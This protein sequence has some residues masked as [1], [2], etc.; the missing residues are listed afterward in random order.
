MNR[1]LNLDSIT[2]VKIQQDGNAAQ[3][4]FKG[5]TGNAY[6]ITLDI[7]QVVALEQKLM[8]LMVASSV[9]RSA[10]S[11]MPKQFDDLHDVILVDSFDLTLPRDGSL[12]LSIRGRDQR[13]VQVSFH[14]QHA[15]ALIA[16]MTELQRK[17]IQIP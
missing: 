6:K 10:H 2:E 7:R 17:G 9:N 3:L 1:N 4:T 8:Q 14:D 11:D 12:S 13:F 16:A 5:K 15:K